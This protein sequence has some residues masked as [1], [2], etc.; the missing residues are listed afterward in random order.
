MSNLKRLPKSSF[1]ETEAAQYLGITIS[2]LHQLLDQHVFTG[3]CRRPECI[4]FTS[5]DLLLLRYW[6]TQ[7]P[8][9]RSGVIEMPK[10][11]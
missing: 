4:E 11:G 1:S 6:N 10:R 9:P 3:D 7:E 5:S 2:R 8:P